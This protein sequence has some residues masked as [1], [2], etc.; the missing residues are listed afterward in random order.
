L[1]A[2]LWIA[3]AHTAFVAVVVP[4]YLRH[5][6]VTNFLWFSD[7]ALL[8]SVAALWLNPLLAGMMA[9]AALLP[10]LAW[11][12]DFV[13]RAAAAIPTPALPRSGNGLL[14]R[15]HL[16]TYTLPAGVAL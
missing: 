2:A 6:G 14:P 16:R 9:L 1:R 5:Y 3:L 15:G 4:V 11:N 8:V 12:L 13:V 7:V 10:E